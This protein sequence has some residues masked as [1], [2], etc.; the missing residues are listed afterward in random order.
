MDKDKSKSEDELE[1]DKLGLEEENSDDKKRKIFLLCGLI[2]IIFLAIICINGY[3][4]KYESLVYPGISIYNKDLSKL[5]KRELDKELYKLQ[6]SISS[7][8]IS[9]KANK[10]MYT[11]NINDLISDYNIKNISNNIIN[12]KKD[13]NLLEKFTYIISNSKQSFKFE[14]NVDEKKISDLENQIAK[15]TNIEVQEPKVIINDLNISYEDGKSGLKLYKNSILKLII[16]NLNKLDDIEDDIS[17]SIDYKK[18]VPKTSIKDLK[19]VNSKIASYTTSYQSATGR[20]K[21]IENAARKID[22]ILLMPGEEFSY[23]KLIGPVSKSNGYTYAPVISNGKLIQG[24]G[25]GV[26]QVSSTLYNT[27]LKSGIIPTQRRNHSKPVSYVPRGLDATLA[28]GS[29]DYKFKN[30]YNY[31]IVINTKSYNGTLTIEFWSNENTLQNIEYKPVSYINGNRAN[32]YLYGY[33]ESGSK[34]YEKHIDT[35]IYR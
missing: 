27:T 5:S 30:T 17:I 22:D 2:C 25:G 23:E 1:N 8:K 12:Y 26:C 11:I 34:V 13:G 6:K 15:D 3:V 9:I 31:P 32:T 35:S 18:E 33:D 19:Q 29:I 20:G 24:I 14:F 4:S 28:S 7:K 21:N 16:D 10:K